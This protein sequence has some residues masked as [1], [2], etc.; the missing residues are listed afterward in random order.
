MYS[1]TGCTQWVLQS[2]FRQ[3][4]FMIPR[5]T[6]NN[7][8]CSIQMPL[9]DNGHF[10]HVIWC[11]FVQH[12]TRYVSYQHYHILSICSWSTA[13]YLGFIL[14]ESPCSS[15]H[16]SSYL[17]Y[18]HTNFYWQKFHIK[19]FTM[20]HSSNIHSLQMTVPLYAYAAVTW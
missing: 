2:K 20:G 7:M 8:S 12:K 17:T 11:H 1:T 9:K 3:H 18:S 10:Q 4:Y 19:V 16:R 5:H 13:K 6:T 15:P 14:H